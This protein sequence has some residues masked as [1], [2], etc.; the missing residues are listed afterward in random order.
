MKKKK[1]YK[2]LASLPL[3]LIIWLSVDTQEDN[4]KIIGKQIILFFCNMY[5]I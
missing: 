5:R 1:Y 3:N 4:N 2:I